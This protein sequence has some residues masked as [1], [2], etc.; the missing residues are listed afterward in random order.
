M[1][2][3]L[4]Q[5]PARHDELGHQVDGVI[6]QLAELRLV[7]LA[8]G[9]SF[10]KNWWMSREAGRRRRTGCGRGATPSCPPPTAA[11]TAGTPSCR[12]R[13]WR[14]PTAR[15]ASSVVHRCVAV[16]VSGCC[17]RRAA[18]ERE[19]GRTHGVACAVSTARGGAS[20][21]RSEGRASGGGSGAYIMTFC[22]LSAARKEGK[23]A[24]SAVKSCDQGPTRKGALENRGNG[25]ACGFQH[26]HRSRGRP[27]RA[28][29]STTT[30]AAAVSATARWRRAPA[31]GK[32]QEEPCPR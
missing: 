5:L 30:T 9:A 32:G 31:F 11:P 13:G 14:R 20:G 15:D 26:T 23:S 28:P 8:V 10:S 27:R 17:G 21:R 7:G 25:F 29:R 2:Q 1:D 12:C 19:R 22:E 6:A 16:G 18:R 3:H 4:H 24:P